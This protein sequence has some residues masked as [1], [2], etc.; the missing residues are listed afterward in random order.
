[1]QEA[2][3]MESLR[4]EGERGVQRMMCVAAVLLSLLS[5]GHSTPGNS[6]DSLVKPITVSKEDVSAQ[7]LY[8]APVCLYL[9]FSPAVRFL[10]SEAH[11]NK[12]SFSI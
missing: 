9:Y 10:T 5:V 3:H 7:R 11:L 1:M 2:L 6:C 8:F 4:K 12:M